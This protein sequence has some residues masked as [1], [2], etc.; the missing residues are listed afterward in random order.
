MRRLTTSRRRGSTLFEVVISAGISTVVLFSAVSLFLSGA[1]T[2][3]RGQGKIDA[4]TQSRQAVRVIS[5]ALREAMWVSV[6][7]DG[8]GVTYRLPRK[9]VDGA[10]E[11][12]IIWDGIDRRI[13]LDG[14]RILLT[15]DEGTRPICRHI[16]LTDPAS[17]SGT[18]PY[19]I[20]TPGPGAITRRLVVQVVTETNG[21]RSEYVT[22]RK[23]ETVFLRNIPE[24]TR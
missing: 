15:D 20:F 17:T 8:M 19:Q 24:L 23:R 16:R 14:E 6:D 9:T 5:D 10:F 7:G 11:V 13:E 2:W 21:A 12:P 18:A 1:G 4:E 22:G 3:A